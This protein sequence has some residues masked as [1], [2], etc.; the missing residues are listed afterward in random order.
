MADA[1][2]LPELK[3]KWEIPE[4]PLSKSFRCNNPIAEAVRNISGNNSFVGSGVKGNE[5]QR[6][7]I[8]RES[9]SGFNNSIAE[10][11]CALKR[12]GIAKAESAI[13]CRAHKQLEEIR[14]EV[15]YVKL[16]GMTKDLAKAAFNRDSRKDYKKAFEIV[17]RAVRT[18]SDDRVFWE[19]LDENP[20]SE[21]FHRVKLA[22]WKFTKSSM[23]LPSVS[24][25]GTDWLESLKANLVVLLTTI[26][27]T[28]IPKLG[29]KIRRTGLDAA[30]MALPLFSEHP[31]FPPVR[32]ETIHQVKGESIDGVLVLGSSR[33]FNDVVNAVDAKDNTEERRLAYVA[34]TRARHLLLV[35]LPAA[36]FDAHAEKW[37]S[38]GFNI[39]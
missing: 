14:G 18:I 33:F 37:A 23:G 29:Q 9:A 4:K 22:L 25:D 20:E 7:F 31:L 11:Q 8:F 27:I 6:P 36:H 15:H 17:E 26:G 3:E 2:S 12:A 34:M 21:D 39:L 19:C 1:T 28:E 5:H 35:G 24:L 38:W 13:L 32:Q 10:F 30:Q 16:Q